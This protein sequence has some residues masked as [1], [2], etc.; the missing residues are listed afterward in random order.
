[1]TDESFTWSCRSKAPSTD[2]CHMGATGAAGHPGLCC[3]PLFAGSNWQKEKPRRGTGNLSPQQPRALHRTTMLFLV[4]LAPN[5]FGSPIK[6]PDTTLLTKFAP[7]STW[8]L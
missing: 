7:E 2:Q 6:P 3:L 5:T 1:M 4:N 8:G